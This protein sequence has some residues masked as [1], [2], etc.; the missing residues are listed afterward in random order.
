MKKKAKKLWI[1]FIIIVIIFIII[2]GVSL[3]S[4]KPIPFYSDNIDFNALNSAN[5]KIQR[6]FNF[7]TDNQVKTNTPRKISFSALE[8]NALLAMSITSAQ[9]F[10][11]GNKVFSDMIARFDNGIFYFNASKKIGFY[12]PFG[13]YINIKCDFKFNLSDKTIDFKVLNLEIGRIPVPH[14][15]IDY[16]VN[17]KK[18][19][20]YAV[21]VVQKLLRSVKEINVSKNNI[22]VIYYPK[23]LVYELKGLLGEHIMM[24]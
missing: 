6:E 3:I 15:V 21:P 18:D 9:T 12:T 24:R 17:G 16:L 19:T 20:I 1:Y 7:L 13:R 23:N 14:F 4:W 8:I 11:S 5:R 2:L 22:V 10:N